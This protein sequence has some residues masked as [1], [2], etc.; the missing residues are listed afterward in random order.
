LR[1]D[2]HIAGHA[3][4][5]RPVAEADA[6]YIVELRTR[7][8]E[9]LNRGA[10]STDGQ[11]Q[12]LAQYFG[13]AGDFYFV[14][15]SIDGARREGLVGVYDLQ[16]GRRDAEWGRWVLEPGSNAAVE[17]ALLVYR[18]VF[19]R[20]RLERVRCRTLVHNR[21]VVAF[22]D[23][24]G[25]LRMPGEIAIRHNGEVHLAVE[26]SVRRADAG[27]VVGRLDRLASRFA[28]IKRRSASCT[29]TP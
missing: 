7:S 5:L 13:R 28:M 8:G 18:C 12:W 25:L 29:S 15:E 20:L 4:R 1:H 26:H 6:A 22:H 9:F 23:S 17:S 24:C 10:L 19:V 11:L 21:K 14:I 27:D 16:A 2:L 3:F